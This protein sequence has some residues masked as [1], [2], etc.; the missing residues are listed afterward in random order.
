MR[1]DGP[2]SYAAALS[3]WISMST[4]RS[5]ACSARRG[6]RRCGCTLGGVVGG[7]MAVGDG[8]CWSGLTLGNPASGVMSGAVHGF[9]VVGVVSVNL[10]DVLFAMGKF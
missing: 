7:E 5:D 9:A 1:L 8:V 2:S 3:H 6:E 10:G 4:A